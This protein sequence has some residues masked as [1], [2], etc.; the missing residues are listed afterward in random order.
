M[1]NSGNLTTFFLKN[2]L[3]NYSARCTD[4]RVAKITILLFFFAG[5]LYFCTLIIIINLS[6]Y[7]KKAYFYHHGISFMPR[8]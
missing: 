4:Y 2:A 8:A 6:T 7:A 5:F 3:R 1:Q